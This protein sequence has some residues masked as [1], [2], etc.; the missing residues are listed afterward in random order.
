MQANFARGHYTKDTRSYY[1]VMAI[2]TTI[3]NFDGFSALTL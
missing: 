2:I 3:L 1:Q